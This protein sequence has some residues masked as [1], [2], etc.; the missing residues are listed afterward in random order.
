MADPP[1][2]NLVRI[3]ALATAVPATQVNTEAIWSALGELWGRRMPGATTA[4]PRSR[5]L[6]APLEWLMQPHGQSERTQQ[7]RRH[8][9]ELAFTVAQRVLDDSGID[10]A[11]VG[12]FVCVSCT[13]FVLPSL[14]AQLI[15]RLGLR[16][17][18]TRLPITEL[19]CGAGVSGISQA[20]QYLRAHPDR[21][22][23]VVAVELP[24]LTFQ[25]D[26]PSADNR[27]A[28][29]VFGDGAGAALLQGPAADGSRNKSPAW[30][31]ERCGT[32]LI[33]E[34]ANDLGYELRDGGLAVVLTRRLAGLI[35][36]CLGD[37]VDRFLAEGHETR[38]DIDLVVAH[39]GGTR[40]LEAIERALGLRADQLCESRRV[41]MEYGNPSSAG[42]FFVLE[43]LRRRRS[44]AQ[45]LAISFG[46]GLSIELARLRLAS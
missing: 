29:L 3:A 9:L 24:S 33:P 32:L 21:A 23:L 26:D 37:A 1:G 28:A 2:G 42:I 41:F 35:E 25:P 16:P 31:V 14:D 11:Q 4:M 19:G 38:A 27:L 20:H 18:T 30:Q 43:G 40:I 44:A 39:P 10:P 6:A 15:P 36:S 34:G 45:A 13:G 8:A 22:C 17:Q 12:Q 46:P 7:Y 5:F